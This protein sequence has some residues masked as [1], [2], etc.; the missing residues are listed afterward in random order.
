MAG[1]GAKTLR[2]ALLAATLV[3]LAISA[4]ATAEVVR[5]HNDTSGPL[6]LV[7]VKVG[8]HTKTLSIRLR[9]ADPLPPLDDLDGHPSLLGKAPSRY[10]CVRFKSHATGRRLLCP[11]G[12]LHHDRIDVGIS[13][14]TKKGRDVPRGAVDVRAHRG[15]RTLAF[16]LNLRRI[17]LRPGR[18]SFGADSRWDGSVC[19]RPHHHG[20]HH[21]RPLTGRCIDRAPQR[22]SGRT[23]IYP[24]ERVGCGGFSQQKVFN[25]S[26]DG[27]DVALTFDDGPSTYT[28]QFLKVLADHH[29]H[30]TF[31]EIGEQVPTYPSM[32]RD[33]VEQGNEV[34]DHSLHHEDAPGE[35]SI[36]QTRD[37]IEGASGFKPCMFRPP[38]GY[39]PSSTLAAAEALDMVSVI[40]DVDTRDWTLPGSD[41]IYATATSAKP[42]SIVLMHDGGGDRSETLAALPRIIENLK[43]RGFHLVT[44]THLLNGHYKYAEDHGHHHMSRLPDPGPFPRHREG[45]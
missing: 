29:V 37:L 45:P 27:K 2:A 34:E 8:Q 38:G 6:D 11:G 16:D 19:H 22:K 25:G 20:G 41:A 31:F 24:L 43:S 33:I 26:R 5:D 18:L 44:M 9:T 7:Q 40:W 23:Q 36:K 12:D 39:E 28:P 1:T 35:D 30:A 32:V 10:L 13:A 15:R 3:L 14:V 42:G 4:P 17:G 21:Q